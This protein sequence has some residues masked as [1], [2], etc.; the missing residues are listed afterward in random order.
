MKVKRLSLDT[1][2]YVKQLKEL[3]LNRVLGERL[4]TFV[5]NP[6]NLAFFI[7]DEEEVI[8]FAWGYI[9]ERFDAGNMMYVH[10]VDVKEGHRNQG[11]GTILIKAFL[12]HARKNGFRNTFLITD[13]SNESANKLF[14]H[15]SHQIE[16]EK[17][18]YIFKS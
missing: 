5:R 12:A 14:K 1:V 7:V 11:I 10:S 18:L 3:S 4:D 2:K 16:T 6:N 13:D 17:N 9:L 8:G 15:F